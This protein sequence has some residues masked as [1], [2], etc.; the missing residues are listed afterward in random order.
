MARALVVVVLA[1]AGC[2]SHY[3]PREPSRDEACTVAL[4]EGHDAYYDAYCRES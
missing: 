2:T 3:G 4:I 1:L